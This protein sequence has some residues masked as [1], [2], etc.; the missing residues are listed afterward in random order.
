[1]ANKI[2]HFLN[3]HLA[4]GF[5]AG[6][7]PEAPGTIG[8][9]VG[10]IL[11]L[12]FV[13]KISAFWQLVVVVVAIAVAIY[14]SGWMAEAHNEKDPSIVVADEIVGLFVT[15]LWLPLAFDSGRPAWSLLI[16]GF[17]LFRI[18]DIWKLWP[19]RKLETLPGGFGI[20]LDDVLAGV[21][22][23]IILQIWARWF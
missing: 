19:I 22:A 1:L 10:L 16:V 5:G 7:S 21:Y 23:N 13:P 8:T 3:Y 20:V 2:R 18:F 9:L 15:Y 11:Y 12:L 14:V 4:T 17:L 6:R